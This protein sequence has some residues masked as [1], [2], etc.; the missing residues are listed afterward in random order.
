MTNTIKQEANDAI[1]TLVRRFSSSNS[2]PVERSTIK[3]HEFH[4][5]LDYI[6][7][8]QLERHEQ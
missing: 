8:L 6:A 4:A 1:E 2:T 3:D 7:L 5:I